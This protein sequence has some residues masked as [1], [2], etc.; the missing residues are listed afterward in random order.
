MKKILLS[1]LFMSAVSM[2]AFA[3]DDVQM[4]NV[5]VV[6]AG[7]IKGSPRVVSCIPM[8]ILKH[9][10]VADFIDYLRSTT[11]SDGYPY[12]DGNIS[13]IA[14]DRSSNGSVCS[15][16]KADES[17]SYSGEKVDQNSEISALD[18][19]PLDVLYSSYSVQEDS[20]DE[21]SADSSEG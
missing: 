10:T 20:V 18:L 6:G 8:N 21:D 9:K 15:P 13:S 1:A 4:N 19:Q 16:L 12:V 3:G 17:F 11:A 7:V 14:L 5:T 2:T